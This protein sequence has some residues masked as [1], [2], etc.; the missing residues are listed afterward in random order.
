LKKFDLQKNFKSLSAAEDLEFGK[1][2]V[3]NFG[4]T[5]AGLAASFRE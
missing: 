4:M 2:G 3:S 5:A 1:V